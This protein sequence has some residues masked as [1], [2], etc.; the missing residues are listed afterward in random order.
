MLALV[1]YVA[2]GAAPASLPRG[3]WEHEKGGAAC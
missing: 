1:S 2:G 3:I